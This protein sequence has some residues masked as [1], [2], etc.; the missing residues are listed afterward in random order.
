MGVLRSKAFAHVVGLGPVLTAMSMIS[1]RSRRSIAEGMVDEVNHVLDDAD[2]MIP[3]DTAAAAESRWVGKPKI[4]PTSVEVS[5]GYG[6]AMA[7]RNRRNPVWP[8]SE[9]YVPVIHETTSQQFSRGQRKFLEI[10]FLAHQD[11]MMSR[12]TSVARTHF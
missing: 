1:A 11:H 9:E 10:P 7:E 6:P 3:V 12:I 4:T 5:G 8:S 2:K